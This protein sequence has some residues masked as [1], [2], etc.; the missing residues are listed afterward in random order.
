M[1]VVLNSDVIFSKA[2]RRSGLPAHVQRFLEKCAIAQHHIVIPETTKLEFEKAQ[3]LAREKEVL[4][5]Q[6]AITTLAMCNIQLP[7]IDVESQFPLLLIEDLLGRIDNLNFTIEAATLEDYRVALRKASKRQN[8]H[9]PSSDMDEMRDLVIWQTALRVA[10]SHHGAILVSRD[11]VHI[12]H[13]GDVEANEHGLLRARDFETA[14]EILNLETASA[15]VIRGLLTSQWQAI[16][17]SGLPI[18]H[19]A[20]IVA[21][22]N[23]EF[24]D[25]EI[26]TTFGSCEVSL[27][28]GDGNVIRCTARLEFLD[29]TLHRLEIMHEEATYR[30]DFDVE[31]IGSDYEERLADLLDNIGDDDGS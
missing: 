7:E 24:V 23:V 29:Q 27:S 10:A 20:A 4:K 31:A 14:E 15:A 19:G 26:G 8:P 18:V 30:S 28:S 5:L 2:L 1:Q 17:G 22:K 16:I 3:E 6:E 21:I 11:E 9:P 25:T 13:R 12:H